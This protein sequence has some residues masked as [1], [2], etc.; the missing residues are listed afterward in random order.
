VSA[1]TILDDA[2]A[3]VN[4]S[5]RPWQFQSD[6]ASP[7]DWRFAAQ[8]ALDGDDSDLNHYLDRMDDEPAPTEAD[9]EFYKHDWA[10]ADAAARQRRKA[11]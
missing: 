5:Y 1:D 7:A 3:I 9:Y 8:C 2:R 6:I 4:G 10:V 11:A